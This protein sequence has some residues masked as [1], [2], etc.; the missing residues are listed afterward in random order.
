MS[1]QSYAK[2]QQHIA[3]LQAQAAKL[4]SQEAAG[5]VARIK[6]AIATY[7][8]TRQDLFAGEPSAVKPKS[9]TKKSSVAK[10]IDG[11]GGQWVGRGKRPTWLRDALA[12]GKKLEDFVADKFKTAVETFTSTPGVVAEPAAKAAPKKRGRKAKPVAKKAASAAKY[13]DGAGNSWSG[14][15][16]TPKWLKDAIAGGKKREDFL[17]KA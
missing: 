16:P 13:S 10:Y 11:K 12:A 4:R 2:L 7:G 3:T 9:T 1:T 8:L 17:G 5:V 14:K 15:G 6:E